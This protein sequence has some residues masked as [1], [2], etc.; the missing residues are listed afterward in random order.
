MTSSASRPSSLS[1]DHHVKLDPVL[2]LV[3]FLCSKVHTAIPRGTVHAF[4]G[5]VFFV[6]MEVDAACERFVLFLEKDYSL[7][8][9]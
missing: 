7:N 2:V 9:R 1:L 3:C 5:K 4:V 8:K 6:L